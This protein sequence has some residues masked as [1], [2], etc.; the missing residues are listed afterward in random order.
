MGLWNKKAQEEVGMWSTI[1]EYALL[2][3]ALIIIFIIF[4][5]IRN[6]LH[7]LYF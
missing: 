4:N 2:A 3:I 5:M 1:K 7:N 6:R